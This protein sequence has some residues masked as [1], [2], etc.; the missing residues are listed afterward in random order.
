MISEVNDALD[1]LE[2]IDYDEPDEIMFDVPPHMFKYWDTVATARE[3]YRSTVEYYFSGAVTT[4]SAEDVSSMITRWLAQIESGM[5]RAVKFGSH[6]FEDDGKSGIPPSYFSY[7][8]T[9]WKLNGKKNS[10]GLPLVNATSL[11][12]GRSPLFLE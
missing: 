12:V 8:V 7:N 1:V 5:T 3:N 10:V 2:S 6:G 4:V 9:A 11:S